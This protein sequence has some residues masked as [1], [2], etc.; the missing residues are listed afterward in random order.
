LNLYVNSGN[1]P[2]AWLAAFLAS[3]ISGTFGL[4]ETKLYSF[5]QFLYAAGRRLLGE[6]SNIMNS[7]WARGLNFFEITGIAFS[8]IDFS[9]MVWYLVQF[10]ALV[11]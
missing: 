9:F 6:I 1:D 8:L 3:A 4:F 10:V 11:S 5:L 7:F 2:C